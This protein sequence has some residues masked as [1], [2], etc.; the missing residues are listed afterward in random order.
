[1]A[2]AL[3]KPLSDQ[4][5][6]YAEQFVNA[7][8]ILDDALAYRLVQA[9]AAVPRDQFVEESFALRAQEDISLPVGFDRMSPRPSIQARMFGLVGLTRGMRVLEVGAGAGYGAA[10]MT[11]A[12]VQVYAIESIGLLAQRTRKLLDSLHFESVLI[13]RGDIKKGWGDHAPFDA[14]IVS[15]V[16][17]AVPKDL[18][19]Q[20]VKPGGRLVA[21]VGTSEE[22][23]ITLCQA[24]GVSV[25]TYALE[26]CQLFASDL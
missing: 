25:S 5:L 7:A 17:S 14:I 26:K 4:A 15:D 2:L 21:A 12:G 11:A 13:R 10:V 20:L 23:T 1:M 3:R 9:F 18:L 19:D 8:G 16:V 6:A 24:K 22:Q